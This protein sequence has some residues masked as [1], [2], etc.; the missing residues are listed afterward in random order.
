MQQGNCHCSE[1][2]AAEWRRDRGP[3]IHLMVDKCLEYT[4]YIKKTHPIK[5]DKQICL[6]RNADG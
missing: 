5:N 6:Q 4:M 2:A 3:A 1:E